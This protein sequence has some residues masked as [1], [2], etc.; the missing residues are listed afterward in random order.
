G[1]YSGRATSLAPCAAASAIRRPAVSRFGPTSGPEVI[2][3]AA[4]RVVVMASCVLKIL[5]VSSALLAQAGLLAFRFLRRVF[6][7]HRVLLGDFFFNRLVDVAA[8]IDL[9]N[10]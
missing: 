1:K 3:M 2:W 9:G 6:V 4:M 5:R 8:G 10:L 7:Q